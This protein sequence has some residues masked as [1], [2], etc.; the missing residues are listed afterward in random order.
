MGGKHSAFRLWL[1]LAAVAALGFALL[2]CTRYAGPGYG[3]PYTAAVAVADLSG[4]GRLD[5]V[6]SNT[7]PGGSGF[8]TARLA[9]PGGFLGPLRSMCGPGPGNLAVGSLGGAAPAVVVVNQGGASVLLADPSQPGLFLAPIA[10]SVGSRQPVD[11]ALGDLDGHG[12]FAVAVAADGGSDLLLF[13]QGSGPGSFALPVSLPVGGTP[14]AVAMADLDGDGLLDLVVATSNGLISVLLQDPAH[15][16][17]FLP[18]ADYAAGSNPVSVKAAPLA[19]GAP[20]D[21][22]A[23]NF[24]TSQAPTLQGLSVLA[25]DP[26]HPGAFL[27][28]VTY[29]AGDYGSCSA[30]VGDLD[31]DGLADIA[32]ANYGLPGSPGSVSVFRQDPANPGTFLAP[33]LYGGRYG[34]T[35]VA[36]G[37]LNGD[38]LPDLAVADGG[39]VVRFQLAGQP[40]Q[41]GPP[42]GLYQ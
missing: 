42:L 6:A 9:E 27:P 2:N 12:A 4:Q 7:W 31:G 26:A 16:G 41:F 40:G 11:V 36:I 24:G 15:L 30:T 33:T 19:S 25:H 5:L 23:A 10:L 34:P 32:V 17:S 22:V 38:G 13:V 3:Q 37:D 18:H 39:V 28:A 1:T 21:L 35:S 14:S 29:S 20:P 8:V